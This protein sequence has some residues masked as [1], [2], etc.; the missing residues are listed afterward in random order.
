MTV[1]RTLRANYRRIHA[2]FATRWPAP[3]NVLYS[4]KANNALAVRAIL[5][6]E[7][8]GGDCFGLGELYATLEGGADPRLVVMNGSNKTE[9]EIDAALAQGITINVDAPDELEFLRAACAR[10][11][12]RAKVN[13]R[14]KVLPPELDRHVNELHPSAHGYVANLRRVKWGFVTEGARPLVEALLRMQCV[15]LTGYH[16][17]VGHLSKAPEASAAVAGAVAAAVSELARATG[18][19]PQVLDLGGGWAPQRDPSFREA[20]RQPFGIEDYAAATTAALRDGL[21]PMRRSRRCG[22]S[23]DATSSATLWCC[24]RASARSSATRACAGCTS[25]RAPTTCRASS[26]GTSTTWCCRPHG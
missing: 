21:G 23:R 2:A 8:A 5:S 10:H 26:P 15:E 22:S 1:E 3:V 17:H 12:R 19:H 13:L 14:L 7:G 18:F 11:G 20:G 4:I 16:C 9:A 6:S 25:T 24:S